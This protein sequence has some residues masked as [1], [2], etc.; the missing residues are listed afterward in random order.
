MLVD[1]N[2]S[3][4]ALRGHRSSPSMVMSLEIMSMK[5]NRRMQADERT[6][7]RGEDSM[8]SN[9]TRDSKGSGSCLGLCIC[10]VVQMSRCKLITESQG[11]Y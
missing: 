11:W 10:I 2:G 9:L 4:S 1:R 6:R 3:I 5:A 7:M 8:A